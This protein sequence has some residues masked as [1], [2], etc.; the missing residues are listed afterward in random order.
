MRSFQLNT[1]IKMKLSMPNKHLN[2]SN[3]CLNHVEKTVTTFICRNKECFEFPVFFMFLNS[4][5]TLVEPDICKTY[6]QCILLLCLT[7]LKL[8]IAPDGLCDDYVT[9]YVMT[10]SHAM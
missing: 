2:V 1:N 6:V 3:N 8:F 7:M 9:C 10:M 5:S 4:N